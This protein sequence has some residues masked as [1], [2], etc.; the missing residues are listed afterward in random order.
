[1]FG[2]VVDKIGGLVSRSFVLAIFFPFVIFTAASAAV[3]WI[4]LPET[5]PALTTLFE[6]EPGKQAVIL[7][8]VLIMIA[9]I[10]YVVSP[11]TVVVRRILEGDIFIP[12]WLRDMMRTEQRQIA[13]DLKNHRDQANESDNNA[14]DIFDLRF[15]QLIGARTTGDQTNALGPQASAQIVA[16][17]GRLQRA[18]QLAT[19]GH[20]AD[21]A[22]IAALQQAID[23]TLLA[24]RNSSTKLP[25]TAPQAERALASRLAGCQ[26]QAT[27]LLRQV[28]DDAH[29]ALIT[30]QEALRGRFAMKGIWPTRIAN[31]R[32]AAESHGSD[33]YAVEFDFLWPRLKLV[34][35]KDDKTAAL[36]EAAKT[37]VDFSLLMVLLCGFF[38][39]GWI[40]VLVC[41]GGSPLAVIVLGVA[42]QWTILFFLQVVEESVKQLGELLSATIDFYRFKLLREMDIDLP[43]NLQAERALWRRVQQ[44]STTGLGT[45]DIA[46]RHS[47]P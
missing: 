45:V 21:D 7:A 17:E 14:S 42:G 3:A 36:I 1:M 8:T 41:F 5:R 29:Q 37:Q 22:T 10:A 38:T 9:V 25:D 32:A 13:D 16:A 27:G 34:V 33:A 43:G 35:Q 15:N 31:I 18:K 47:K 46:Y 24:L 19:P 2:S 6:I 40:I 12:G 26:T 4:A 23:A 28:V 44:S 39:A 11:L 30:R 20:A